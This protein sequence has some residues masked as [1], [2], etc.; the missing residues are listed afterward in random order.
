MGSARDYSISRSTNI[1]YYFYTLDSFCLEGQHHE[2]AAMYSLLCVLKTLQIELEYVI[3][4]KVHN[5]KTSAT[6]TLPANWQI[7]VGM[8]SAFKQNSCKHYTLLPCSRL[9]PI[10]GESVCGKKGRRKG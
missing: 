5:I 4:D 1:V 8:S 6:L 3:C 9:A 2:F 7:H 10:S